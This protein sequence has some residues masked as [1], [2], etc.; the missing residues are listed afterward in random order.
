MVGIALFTM[1]VY[2]TV[3]M[4]QLAKEMVYAMQI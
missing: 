4:K 3:H 1:I 2:Q